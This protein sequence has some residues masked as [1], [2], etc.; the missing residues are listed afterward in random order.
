MSA[1]ATT[2]NKSDIF[3]GNKRISNVWLG[4]FLLISLIGLY[5]VFKKLTIGD[6]AYGVTKTVPW[7]ILISTYVFFVVS[8][9]G[10]C[11]ISSMGHVFGIEKY[12]VIGK[13]AIILAIFTLLC[14][15]GVIGLEL[16]H[17]FRMMI[18]NII[19]PNLHS[20][21]WWMG[22]LYGV[23]LVCIAIE[24]YFL[25]THNHT[26]A[27]IAGLAGFLAGISA[28]S[29]LGAVFGFL[30]ARPFW[31][32]PYLPIYFILSAL[33]SGT[34]L[35]LII[36]NVAYGGPS[37]L[38]EKAKEA[39]K[40]LSKIFG[41]LLG[42]IIFFDIWKILTSVYGMPPE[43]YETVKV[44]LSGDLAINFWIFEVMLGM[45]IPFLIIIFTKGNS[46]KAALVAAISAV[47]GIF[48]MRYDLVIAGQMV[49]M[50]EPVPGA[51]VQGA[52]LDGLVHYSPSFA[53]ISIVIGA[54]SFCIFLYLLAE[55]VLN[56][57]EE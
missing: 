56:L 26:G 16:G 53:E 19:S 20:A 30:E 43:K 39:L 13:R 22:T 32:G 5:G 27:Q 52:G 10:L 42:I 38:P 33:I 25:M 48:F 50:R 23:Y 4:I 9:T 8:S 21:I 2:L 34:A 12:E 11:L 35:I 28:H 18:Y 57:S 1:H 49:P 46:V 14:G 24:F 7:G 15:F 17:P 3:N 54:I 51:R 44:L 31:H 41:L 36:M 40:G 55:K 6:A 37:K 29:N 45:V 47:I